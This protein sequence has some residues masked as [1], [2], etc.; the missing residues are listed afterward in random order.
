MLGV[1]SDGTS[2]PSLAASSIADCSDCV[3]SL[4]S[5]WASSITFGL[6]VFVSASLPPSISNRSPEIEV[7]SHVTSSPQNEL[8]LDELEAELE[9]V[10][11]LD[12]VFCSVRFRSP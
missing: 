6:C 9:V 1:G 8:S 11:E 12:A 5:V 2:M 4:I 7:C 3:W 10:D